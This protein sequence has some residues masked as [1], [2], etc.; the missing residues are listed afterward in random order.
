[1][2]TSGALAPAAMQTQLRSLLSGSTSTYAPA[3]AWKA[4]SA[5]GAVAVTSVS[6]AQ[7][8][9]ASGIASTEAVGRFPMAAPPGA[10]LFHADAPK[11][12]RFPGVGVT[13]D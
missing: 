4:A 1:V 11:F 7:L 6:V 5:S 2:Y 9:D 12:P 8:L 13:S 3:L 10:A